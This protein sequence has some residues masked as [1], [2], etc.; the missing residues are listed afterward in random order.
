M[1]LFHDSVQKADLVTVKEQLE[2]F[3]EKREPR[4]ARLV[5]RETSRMSESISYDDITNALL[6]GEISEEWLERWRV[7]YSEFLSGRM[8]L[9]RA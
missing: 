6:S 7:L 9:T 4:L 5:A 8:R 3:V 1:I 2:R